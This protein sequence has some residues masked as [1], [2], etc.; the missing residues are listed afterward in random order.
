[1]TAT[2]ERYLRAIGSS[3][4]E[5]RPEPCDLDMLIVAGWVREG[6]GTALLRLRAEFDSVKR[7][8]PGDRL[9]ITKL[10][11]FRSTRAVLA[12]FAINEASKRNRA[13]SEDEVVA[14]AAMTLDAF[15]DPLCPLCDGRGFTGGYAGPQIRCMACR[16]SGRRSIAWDPR[17]EDFCRWLTCA[18][19]GKVDRVLRQMWRFSKVAA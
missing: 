3:H 19:E 7:H 17:S 6:L 1:M 8:V 9:L 5:L 18:I 16:Q 2:A 14:A 15:L 10:K 13:L 4:L 12:H 11:S